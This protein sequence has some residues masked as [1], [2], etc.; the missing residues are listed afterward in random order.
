MKN[1]NLINVLIILVV[2]III[3]FIFSVIYGGNNSS[4]LNI[5]QNILYGVFIG[6]SISISGYLTRLIIRN[7]DIQKHPLRTYVIL[8]VLIFLFISIDVT[9]LNL[10]WYR[11]VHGLQFVQII[12]SPGI[13]LLTVITV[14][15]GLTI[16]FIIL[17]KSYMVRLVDAEKEIQKTRQEA[18]IAKFETLKSQINPHFL[19][20]SLNTLS[21]LILIDTKKADQFTSQLSNIYRY[22][23][24]NQDEDLV[25]VQKELDF[26]KDYIELQSIRFSNNFTISFQEFKGDSNSMIIPMSLQL[27]LENV[28]KHNII[29]QKNKVAISISFEDNYIV[30]RNNKTTGK[31]IRVS[32]SVGLSNIFNR[33]EAVC[34]EQCIIED[35]ANSFTV[36]L[37]LVITD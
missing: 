11:Y 28:F 21:T 8:L 23:L 24:D 19:F 31:E 35:T 30:V 22:V 2:S 17:S 13:I 1:K 4:F 14:F 9:V 29:S 34:D 36:K 33:Y 25:P 15:I 10:L 26:A 20:N 16:F 5:A 12:Y 37:P 27:L 7:S 6:G 3:T 32:H 18:D